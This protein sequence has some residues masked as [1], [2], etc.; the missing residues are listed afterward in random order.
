MLLKAR[1]R[2]NEEVRKCT[3]ESRQGMAKKHPSEWVQTELLVSCFTPSC[4]LPLQTLLRHTGW[5]FKSL[6]ASLLPSH[7][8]PPP[9][10]NSLIHLLLSNPIGTVPRQIQVF[11]G[12]CHSPPNSLLSPFDHFH[13]PAPLPSV[14][15]NL[16]SFH[17]LKE[18]KRSET[19]PHSFSTSKINFLY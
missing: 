8:Q 3:W 9:T 5:Q 4:I 19:S 11:S 10:Q 7:M 12:L 18:R 15:W 17:T 1:C 16:R 2:P 14:L 13:A 6:H